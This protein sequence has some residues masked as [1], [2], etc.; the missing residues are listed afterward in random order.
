MNDKIKNLIIID[1]DTILKKNMHCNCL[2]IFN[3]CKL[4]LNGYRVFTYENLFI[5]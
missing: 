3:G 5:L 2:I 4:I 1:S